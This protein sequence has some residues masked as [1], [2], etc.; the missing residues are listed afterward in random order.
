M[1]KDYEQFLK[2]LLVVLG[3]TRRRDAMGVCRLFNPQ[4]KGK[5][6]EGL[7]QTWKLIT[8]YPPDL[9]NVCAVLN[10]CVGEPF[11]WAGLGY[12]LQLDKKGSYGFLHRNAKPEVFLRELRLAIDGRGPLSLGEMLEIIWDTPNLEETTMGI[13]KPGYGVSRAELAWFL[14]EWRY[15]PVDGWSIVRRPDKRWQFIRFGKTD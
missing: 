7:R 2:A 3:T 6:R 1:R 12:Y 15:K 10:S 11:S 5:E 8:D 9:N 4:D 13:A 14:R